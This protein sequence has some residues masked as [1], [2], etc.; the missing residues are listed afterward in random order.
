MDGFSI[1]GTEVVNTG[2]E[3]PQSGAGEILL[4]AST[5]P[6]DDDEARDELT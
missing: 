6:K 4:D 2:A 1:Y 5:T 3:Y